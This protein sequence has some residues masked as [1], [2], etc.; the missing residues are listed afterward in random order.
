MVLS[1]KTL[2]VIVSQMWIVGAACFGQN[3]TPQ[4]SEAD[5]VYSVV[6]ENT[7]TLPLTKFLIARETVPYST[8]QRH[9]PVDPDNVVTTEEFDKM[10]AA[11]SSKVEW[12]AIFRRRACIEVPESEL[13]VYISAMRDYRAK[14]ITSRQLRPTLL[15]HKPY[16]VLSKEEIAKRCGDIGCSST[17]PLDTNGLFRFSAVGFSSD[18]TLAIVYVGFDCPL[19]GRWRLHVLERISGKWRELPTAC[20]RVS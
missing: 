17:N 3:P 5:E 13:E 4:A 14:N 12:N 9:F 1:H 19:C 20:G 16:E 7:T 6:I 18:S 2:L 8:T 15:L 10:L 11:A